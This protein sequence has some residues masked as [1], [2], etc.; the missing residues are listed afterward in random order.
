MENEDIYEKGKL[1]KQASTIKEG[2][3][4][5]ENINCYKQR[6]KQLLDA[7][8]YEQSKYIHNRIDEI[9]SAKNQRQL[10]KQ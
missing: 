2:N 9:T 8:D 4:T 7:Y 3:P 10:E 6:Q 5:Q 1:L